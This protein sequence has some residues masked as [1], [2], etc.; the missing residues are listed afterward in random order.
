[1]AGVL[2]G[3]SSCPGR[4]L[5]D[6]CQVIRISLVQPSWARFLISCNAVFS[7]PDVRVCQ[8]RTWQHQSGALKL[9]RRTVWQSGPLYSLAMQTWAV[10]NR[11]YTYHNLIG[12]FYKRHIQNTMNEAN[13]PLE[14]I[15]FHKELIYPTYKRRSV[16]LFWPET[17][18]NRTLLAW[19][20]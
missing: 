14:S 16:C 4:L 3:C 1:M 19:Y 13:S 8:A 6:C 5:C 18:D 15:S 17:R 7:D 11:T 10:V 9:L 12:M 20:F 2:T